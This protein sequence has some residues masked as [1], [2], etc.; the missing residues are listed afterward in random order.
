MHGPFIDVFKA[1]GMQSKL[2]IVVKS[3]M[4]VHRCSGG[5]WTSN[6]FDL[7][8]FGGRDPSQSLG[9]M[10]PN[11]KDREIALQVMTEFYSMTPE[12]M[13]KLDNI[14]V[15]DWFAQWPEISY[16]VYR[17]FAYSLQV[18]QEGLPEHMPMSVVDNY[19]HQTSQPLGVPQGWLRPPDGGC[20]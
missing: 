4:I 7:D 19:V 8:N 3:M 6:P 15:T 18:N 14:T 16:S 20:G 12:Q 2:D 5:Q 10:G 13:D 9:S 17:C 11:K 1:L